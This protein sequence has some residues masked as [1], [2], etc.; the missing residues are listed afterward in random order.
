MSCRISNLH[1]ALGN[2][3]QEVPKRGLIVTCLASRRVTADVDG[4]GGTTRARTE[5]R[6]Y[7]VEA[8]E[9]RLRQY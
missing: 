4:I 2:L 6:L 5:I 3:S 7:G 1:L 9:L 8:L